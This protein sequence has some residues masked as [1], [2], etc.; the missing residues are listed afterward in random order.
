MFKKPLLI[1]L[2]FSISALAQSDNKELLNYINKL[3]AK[4][5]KYEKKLSAV[6]QEIKKIKSTHSEAVN[7]YIREEVKAYLSQNENYLTLNSVS[8]E[9]TLKGDLRIRYERRSRDTKRS[10]DSRDR[11]RQRF[12]LGFTWK[13]DDTPWLIS[14]GF[15]TGDSS[16]T[17]TNDTYSD[18]GAFE[19]GD[20]RLDYAFA[21]RNFYNDFT[22]TI[23]Q[24]KNPFI[25][26]G[27]LWDGDVRPVG[28]SLKYKGENF[29]LLTGAYD[30]IHVGNDANNAFLYAIQAGVNLNKFTSALTYYH[31]T[32]ALTSDKASELSGLP[33]N[34]DEDLEFHTLT[35]YNEYS[36][37]LQDEIDIKLYAELAIN[38]HAEGQKGFG[39]EGNNLD[40][41]KNEHY[42]ALGGSIKYKKFK[43]KYN[44]AYFESDSI[45][46]GLK[47]SDFV[48]SNFRTGVKGHKIGLEYSLSKNVTLG[49]T[50]YIVDEINGSESLNQLELDILYKF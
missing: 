28:V 4:L 26:S 42:F 1:F 40:P 11:F 17:S 44:Y 39:S 43:F 49:S 18:G 15:A 9:I 7:H 5:E 16:A 30:V 6:D 37:K 36:F 41:D 29:F 8:K 47:D 24:Q 22:L 45:Y 2:L 33:E 35:F 27:I 12:R 25:S 3:E 10:D 23:G 14:A 19:T 32:D 46:G 21:Q 31:F 38:L 20:L 34:I 13:S 48:T 50:L